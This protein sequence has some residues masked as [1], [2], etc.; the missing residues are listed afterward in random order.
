MM[1]LAQLARLALTVDAAGRSPV[2]D[3]V[4]A[5]WDIERGTAQFWRSSACHVFVVPAAGPGRRDRSFL[6]FVPAE[7]R[8][9]AGLL[10]VAELADALFRAGGQVARPLPSRRGT[11]TEEV[12]TPLGLMEAMLVE[13]APGALADSDAL[14]AA[15]AEAWGAALAGLHAAG[16]RLPGRVATRLPEGFAELAE[17]RTTLPGDDRALDACA[18][19]IERMASLPRTADAWGVVHGDFELDNVSWDGGRVVAFDLDEAARSWFVADIAF[20]LRDVTGFGPTPTPSEKALTAAFL[21][22]YGQV[23]PLT[24]VALAALPMFAAAH[25]LVS[26]VRARRALDARTPEDPEWLVG[27]RS[28]VEEHARDQRDLAVSLAGRL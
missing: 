16:N 9:G 12:E 15:R 13:A 5:Q 10:P 28:K 27:L 3:A 2:A 22:G 7:H 18:A 21:D 1:P 19:V 11:L 20:S 24:E 23:R 17:V 8:P 26:T 4:A 25:A 14:T 6:R